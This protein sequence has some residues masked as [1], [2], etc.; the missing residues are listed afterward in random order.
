MTTVIDRQ[1][2]KIESIVDE[3][4]RVMEVQNFKKYRPLF[5]LAYEF[6]KTKNVLLYGG[7]AINELLPAKLRF[8]SKEMLSDIDL[9][10]YNAEKVAE[11]LHNAFKKKGHL[12]TFKMGLHENT[13]KVMVD[14]VQVADITSISKQAYMQLAKNG[15]MTAY[16]VRTVNPEYLRLSMHIIL[17][18]PNDARLWSK[19][20]WRLIAFYKAFPPKV[21]KCKSKLTN[22]IPKNLMMYIKAFIFANKYVILGMHQN[23]LVQDLYD[24]ATGMINIIVEQE[25]LDVAIVI[26]N[27]WMDI[28]IQGPYEDENVGQHVILE[29]NGKPFMCIFRATSCLSYVEHGPK[30]YRLASIHTLLR[31]YIGMMVSGMKHF[32][33]SSL[34]CVANVLAKEVVDSIDIGRHVKKAFALECYGQYDGLYTM[35]RKQFMRKINVPI[36]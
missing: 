2:Q 1:I 35:R 15:V 22:D 20:L 33:H 17:S 6:L 31:M 13:W 25:P 28:K 9:Y 12:S 26:A 3:N 24:G 29:S 30:K 34:E 4:T 36:N 21:K 10:S 8:Y 11:Q 7:T 32:D 23:A 18:Q 27:D 16:G 19:T 14:G 5:E